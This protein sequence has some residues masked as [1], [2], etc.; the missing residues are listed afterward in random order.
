MSFTLS[1][2]SATA[3]EMPTLSEGICRYMAGGHDIAIHARTQTQLF[4][5]ARQRAFVSQ[6]IRSKAVIITLHGG[7][8]SFP[9]FD[10]FAEAMAETPAD[11]RPY[12]HVQPTSG[13]EDS[14][15]AVRELSS[16]FGTPVWGQIQC[17][18]N[19]G[20]FVNYEQL[21]FYLHNRLYDTELDWRP[22][23]E[24]PNEG[25]YHPDMRGIP[26]LEEYLE[27]RV[28][29]SRPSVG[30]WFY[31]TCWVNNNLAFID[32]MIRKIEDAGAN[33]IPVF[34]LRYKD[35]Q[36]GNMGADHI[37]DHYFMD[38]DRP[39]IQ[40]L[41]NPLMFSLT[42]AAPEYKTLLPRLNVPFIQTMTCSA[43]YKQWSES[44]QGLPTMDVSYS[45][46]QPEF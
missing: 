18:L 41:I 20:G 4:D 31:R 8:P 30:L 16:D 10:L 33:V 17:Y 14:I 21:L 12:V 2:F 34:H 43:P 5:Q 3:M 27:A 9:A 38:G 35:T 1:Y 11:M 28:D 44:I 6:A 36:R 15:E 24:L 40:V 37:V 29:A 46:A 7:K 19:Y 26:S 32:A 39:R 45:A 22:P 42:L 23:V 13:D 25:I